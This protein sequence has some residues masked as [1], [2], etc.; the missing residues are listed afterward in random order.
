[1]L[2]FNADG[3]GGGSSG[4][5]SS[6]SLTVKDGDGEKTVT[7]DDVIKLLAGQSSVTQIQQRLAAVQKIADKFNLSID[8]LAEQ[9]EGSLSIVGDLID[10]GILTENGEVVSSSGEGNSGNS[11]FLLDLSGSGEYSL[12]R[13]GPQSD[14]PIAYERTGG[15]T[16]SFRR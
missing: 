4:N 12:Y 9:A 6:Q 11:D 7:A 15:R 16:P 14:L 13:S 3:T 10:K 8:Q 2:F 1:M 5:V